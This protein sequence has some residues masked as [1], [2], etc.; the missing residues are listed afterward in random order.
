MR[1]FMSC[2]HR[3]FRF[4]S[5]PDEVWS[6]VRDVAHWHERLFPGVLT[7]TRMEPDRPPPG[8]RV[9]TFADGNEVREPIVTLDDGLRRVAWTVTG[10]PL[11]HHHA[12]MEVHADGTGSRVVWITEVLPDDAGATVAG[13]VDGGAAALQ[14]QLR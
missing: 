5:T 1:F 8:V 7:A 11:A 13:I 14:K 10:G 6:A 2:I 12:S 3:E 9:V 4:V